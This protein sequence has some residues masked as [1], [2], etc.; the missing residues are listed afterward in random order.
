NSRNTH[1][2]DLCLRKPIPEIE[3]AAA[4]LEEAVAEH[5]AGRRREAAALIAKANMPSVR[6]WTESLWGKNSEYAP[7]GPYLPSPAF[8]A[9]TSK[10]MPSLQLQ[11][12]LHRRD[13]Y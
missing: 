13:G 9:S 5:L 11:H 3:H 2:S 4:M 6:G 7:S 12:E 10:R 1:S 8:V